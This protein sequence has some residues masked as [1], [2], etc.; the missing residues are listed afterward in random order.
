MAGMN[1]DDGSVL[2]GWSHVCQSVH[3]LFTT[4]FFTRVMRAYVGSNVIRLLGELTIPQTVQR[5]R[6]AIAIAIDLFEPR[7]DPYRVDLVAM[8]GTGTSTWIIQC[9]YMPNAL[10]GDFTPAGIRSLTIDPSVVTSLLVVAQ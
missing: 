2:D 8:D 3:I 10:Q 1:M 5:I 4:E 7:L 9:I 6:T